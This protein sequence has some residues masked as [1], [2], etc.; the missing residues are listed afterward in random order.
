VSLD[1]P[2]RRGEAGGLIATLTDEDGGA[3]DD[4]LFERAL[5]GAVTRSLAGLGAREATVLRLYFGLGGAAVDREDTMTLEQIGALLGVTRERVRQIRET[6]LA[7]LR[8][9]RRA[10]ALA[11][12]RE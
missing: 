10:R 5:A 7:R 8:H 3:P 12:F 4:L 2:T 9:P 6:A 1:A 11:S